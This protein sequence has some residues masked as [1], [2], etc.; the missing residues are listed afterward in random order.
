MPNTGRLV[1]NESIMH[2][3]FSALILKKSGE[4]SLQTLRTDVLPDKELLVEILYSSINYKDALAVSGSAKI[5]RGEFPF[6]PG[7]DLVGKVR[8]SKVPQFN[9]GSTVILTGGGLGESHW[10]GYSQLQTVD[11]CFAV[12]LPDG[13]SPRTSMVLGTAGLTAMLSVMALENH[14]LV[15]TDVIVT[16]ASGGVGLI[17]VHLLAQLGYKVTASCGSRH[18]DNKL[19][20]LGARTVTG[21]LTPDEKRPLLKGRWDGAVDAAGGNALS[22]VLPQVKRHGCVAASGNA[23][24]AQLRTTVYPF[25]LRGV[26]LYGIDSNT[27]T[28]RNRKIA[29][30]RLSEL[31]SS[32]LADVLLMSTVALADVP[33]VCSA[34]VAGTAPGRFL[35]DVNEPAL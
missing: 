6:V 33:S 30:A 15:G 4:H 13:M 18:L 12:T 3:P 7:I 34:K 21:R 24:G 35:V 2:E 16:G 17:A 8:A 10:G 29:W 19:K 25:I 22:A 20:A 32:R 31:V 23:A 28:L 5:I 9:V 11:S 27:A 14:G 26:V 1:A